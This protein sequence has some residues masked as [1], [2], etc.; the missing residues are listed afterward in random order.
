MPQHICPSC[1]TPEENA[2]AVINEATIDYSQV[3]TLYP[4]LWPDGTLMEN[5]H[6]GDGNPLRGRSRDR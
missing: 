4:V 3:T 2:E 1:Q 6:C 5:I